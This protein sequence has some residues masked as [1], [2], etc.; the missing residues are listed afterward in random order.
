MMD[1]VLPQNM[2]SLVEGYR[3]GEFTPLDAL[4]ATLELVDAV[5]PSI[6]AMAMVDADG[7]RAAA[8]E[9]TSRWAS[10][11]ALS[12]LDGVP[13]TIKDSVNAVG[14]P[15]RHGSAAHTNVPDAEVDSPPAA[16][17][18]E[19]GAVIVGKTTMPDFGMMA[20]GVSSL[21]GIVRNPWDLSRNT[22]GSSAGAGASLA[23][24]IGYAAV[25]TDIAGSVRLPA[26]HCGL[27]ALKPTQGRIPHL[28]SS[29]MRSPGPMA[30]TVDEA[31][32]MY[33][34]IARPDRRDAWSLPAESIEESRW[35]ADVRGLRI[36]VMTDMGYGYEADAAV[37]AVVD[38]AAQVFAVAGAK[39]TR[40]T[41]PFDSDP[42][43][44]LDRLFQVRARAE[45]ESIPEE[46]RGE[47][48]GAVS[49]WAEPA[50]FASATDYSRD[51]EAVNAAQMR[52]QRHL[53]PYDFVI[54]PVIPVVGFAA[55][56]V[57]L[58][59]ERPLAHC[60][61][62]AWFNQTGQPASTLCF[63]MLEGCPVGVQIVGSRF[64]DTDVL[65]MTKWLEDRRR[66]D[67]NWPDLALGVSGGAR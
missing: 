7:A 12:S 6:N 19:A 34:A 49:A 42:Y 39:V 14:M 26:G 62:T 59:P 45:W 20:A 17:L 24:G 4:G 66:F 50:S 21:Y 30:R 58:D 25:G 5:N 40:V 29:M 57:G 51:L 23:A 28:P 63:G 1:K 33:R 38:A 27:V 9:S 37:V 47:V 55:D 11:N 56:T 46:R 3:T 32:A 43:A 53:E 15:W 60:S 31:I 52:I 54:S 41:P 67:M 22:G 65:A 16:R 8:A 48:I 2:S 44:P 61:F 35:E 10:G 18:K 36:G 13:V 64:A